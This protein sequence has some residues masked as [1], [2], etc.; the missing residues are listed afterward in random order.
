VLEALS[1]R[2]RLLVYDVRGHG[3]T[4]APDDPDAYSM[5]VYAQDLNALLDAIEV[6]RAHICGESQGGMIASQ[7]VCDFPERARSFLLCDSTAGNGVDESAGGEWE[8]K[9]AHGFDA[10]ERIAREEGLEAL[11]KRRIAYDREHDPRYFEYPQP[12][13]E[14]EAHDLETYT[15]M[16]LGA[17]IGTARAIARRPD[18]TSRISQLQMPALVLAGEWDD[19]RACAERDHKLMAGSRFVLALRSGHSVSS[20]RRDVFIRAVTEFV[21]DVEAGRDVAGEFEL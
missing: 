4:T 7:F 21:T 11:G 3:K 17:F 6:D 8:R 2:H 13:D 20:W 19:F 9:A 16:S 10:M 1:E 18:L 14:R 5:P 12:I 15:R